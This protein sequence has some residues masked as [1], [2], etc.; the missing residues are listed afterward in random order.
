[1]GRM[2]ANAWKEIRKQ[3]IARDGYKCTRCPSRSN[4]TVHHINNSFGCDMKY[5]ETLCRDCH[6]VVDGTAKRSGVEQ[7]LNKEAFS[8]EYEE[9]RRSYLE[10]LRKV[11]KER[12]ADRKS[13]MRN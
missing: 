8:K 3:V 13:A 9:K 12:E 5:L 11:R 6:D 1:M 2:H 4:L 7:H 10:A